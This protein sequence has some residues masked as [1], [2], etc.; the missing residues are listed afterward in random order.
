MRWGVGDHI[1]FSSHRNGSEKNAREIL[2]LHG[3]Q[4]LKLAKNSK[5][6]NAEFAGI[7]KS[8]KVSYIPPSF[9]SG[10]YSAC[11]SLTAL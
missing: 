9:S 7:N 10:L 11:S 1:A 5:M 6:K 2:R 4:S 3:D 8:N